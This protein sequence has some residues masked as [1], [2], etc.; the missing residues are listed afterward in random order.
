LRRDGNSD[1][2]PK[3]KCCRAA[4][5]SRQQSKLAQWRSSLI[6]PGRERFRSDRQPSLSSQVDATH[7]DIAFAM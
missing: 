2:A 6:T 4:A 5:A 3:A 1:A 7:R